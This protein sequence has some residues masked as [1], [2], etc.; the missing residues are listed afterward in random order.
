MRQPSSTKE[1]LVN[2]SLRTPLARREDKMPGHDNECH[3]FIGN[4][5]CLKY[6]LSDPC[7]ASGSGKTE[8]GFAARERFESQD[9]Y[10][11]CSEEIQ[12]VFILV[13]IKSSHSEAQQ[14]LT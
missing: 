2:I 9:K 11:Q 13:S 5:V 7:V 3:A 10:I 6:F 12:V 4:L 14:T 8:E 1:T